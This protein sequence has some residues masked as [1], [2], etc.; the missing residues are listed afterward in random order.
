ML[1]L[2]ISRYNFCPSDPTI[3]NNKDPIQL[4]KS[5]LFSSNSFNLLSLPVAKLPQDYVCNYEIQTLY[6]SDYG[7]ILSLTLNQNIGV[8]IGLSY[9]QVHHDGLVSTRD[10][11]VLTNKNCNDIL[12]NCT[13]TV[14]GKNIYYLSNTNKA[15]ITVQNDINNQI[16]TLNQ[17]INNSSINKQNDY[18]LK[19]D[20][21]TKFEVLLELNTRNVSVSFFIFQTVVLWLA[22]MLGFGYFIKDSL[23][24]DNQISKLSQ[25][26]Q[27]EEQKSDDLEERKEQ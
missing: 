14:Q 23:S 6:N 10:L 17:T 22:F 18:L 9:Q 4:Y 20:S 21:M 3:C 7:Q 1:Q 27:Q 13:K 8:K 15:F 25:K 5:L 24:Q 16:T 26:D 11:G 2:I 12:N 19:D